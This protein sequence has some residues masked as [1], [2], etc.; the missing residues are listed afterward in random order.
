LFPAGR[1]GFFTRKGTQGSNPSRLS[2]E[3]FSIYFEIKGRNSSMKIK[4]IAEK[5]K[6]SPRA[7]RFY[8]QKGLISPAKQKNNQYRIFSEHE[9]WRLQTIISLRE[10][11]MP[12]EEIKKV[13]AQIEAGDQDELQHYLELQRAVMV[14]Q[15]VELKQ[16]IETTDHMI[17]LI[18]Q[19]QSLALDNIYRLAEGSKRLRELRKNWQDRWNFDR[20]ASSYDEQVK[21]PTQSFNVHQDYDQALELTVKWVSQIDGERGLDI[22]TG[23]GYLAGR[24]LAL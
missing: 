24:F 2:G 18:K 15:W 14:S 5:L 7:I 21:K 10:V 3:E 13:L 17:E 12:I 8:E 16:M 20:L 23:T 9:V 19:N 4:E 22:G 1:R 11:G 6:I